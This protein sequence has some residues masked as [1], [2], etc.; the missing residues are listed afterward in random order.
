MLGQFWSQSQPINSDAMDWTCLGCSPGLCDWQPPRTVPR[1]SQSVAGPALVVFILIAG[2]TSKQPAER[3]LGGKKKGLFLTGPRGTARSQ[4]SKCGPG[5]CLY[6]GWQWRGPTVLRLHFYW[7]ILNIRAGIK[8][9]EW[10]SRQVVS[11]LSHWALSKKRSCTGGVAWSLCGYVFGNVFCGDSI[12]PSGCLTIKK[13]NVRLSE[14]NK[15]NNNCQEFTLQE[16]V[17]SWDKSIS[18]GHKYKF[19]LKKYSVVN[20]LY[21]LHWLMRA[22]VYSQHSMYI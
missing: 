16:T 7:W 17:H 13:L 1:P 18:L 22:W 8:A 12:L 3:E 20:G 6:W 2:S 10:K 5:F 11:H 15:K 9:Q 4:E 14:Y 21:P 19:V